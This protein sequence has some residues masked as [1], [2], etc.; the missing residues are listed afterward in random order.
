MWRERM[1]IL[2]FLVMESLIWFVLANVLAGGSGGIGPSYV[3]LVAATLGGF[4]LTRALQRFELETRT[5]VALG[6]GVSV[7]ALLMLL[8]IQ[9]NPG[10][11][12][13]SLSW[14]A[15]FIESPDGYLASRWPQTWGVIVVAA[16][17][18]RA[19][20]VA[21]QD[22]TY[23][24]VL[25]SFS[26][27]LSLV[28]LVLLL[29]QAS[30]VG[31]AVN[32]A[33]LPFFVC[34]LFALAL[35]QLRRAAQPDAD[36]LRGPWLPVLLGTIVGLALVS[37]AI[38]AFPLDAL[39]HL[40]APV[41]MLAL[42]VLDLII[43]AIALPIGWLLTQIITRLLGREGFEWPR[44]NQAATDA[45]E[46]VQ[47]QG[48]QNVIA[49]F[50]LLVFKFLF[51]LALAAVLA[52]VIYRVFR[53]LRRPVR[54]AEEVRESVYREGSLGSDLAA[55]FRGML[56][57][58]NR[59]DSAREPALPAGILRLRRLYLRVLNDAAARGATRPL[60]ATP[61]EFT[62]V[63]IGAL[64]SSVPERLSE[65]FADGRYG[66]IE[67]SRED[68]AALERAVEKMEKGEAE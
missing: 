19:V 32:M 48:D 64:N 47:Q 23:S 13:V 21:Q 11:S 33:A 25:G 60:P 61:H 59:G 31:Q 22:F 15:G 39:N 30:R 16:A 53:R 40:L 2:S 58:L 41:G 67:P 28:V 14:L 17:W 29:G 6:S 35:T 57:R 26:I 9:Y 54:G 37:I 34:G 56:G 3:T 42:R 20:Q 44:P 51:V 36:F 7:L 68:L 10:G 46:R 24:L 18:F 38:G 62:P 55:L 49:A 1:A 27:G 52:Y 66:R 65:R 45:A 63:L 4:V 12:P 5:L 8:N 50:F 43:L